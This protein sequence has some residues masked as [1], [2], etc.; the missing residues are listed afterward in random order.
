MQ[1][2]VLEETL[3]PR[4]GQGYGQPDEIKAKWYPYRL[5]VLTQS[6]DLVPRSGQRD[7]VLLCRLRDA[8]ELLTTDGRW[9]NKAKSAFKHIRAGR[10]PEH[11]LIHDWDS[12]LDS[13][14][15]KAADFREVYSVP[16]DY[17]ERHAVTL[18]LRPRLN[19]PYREHFSQAYARY[20]MRVGLPSGLPDIS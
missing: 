13:K 19:P 5:I 11:H 6:C 20:H 12:P 16:R 2:D 14:K 17:L 1:G 8:A 15:A 18:G 10:K 4:F 7:Q 3:V 9:S